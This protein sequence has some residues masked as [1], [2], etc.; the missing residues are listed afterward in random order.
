MSTTTPRK[1]AESLPAGFVRAGAR[2]YNLAHVCLVEAVP[3]ADGSAREATVHTLA[4]RVHLTGDDAAEF[5]AALG[6]K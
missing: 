4:G 2:V 1:A 6:S 5:L 3:P